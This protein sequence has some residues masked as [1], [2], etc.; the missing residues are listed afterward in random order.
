MNQANAST[1]PNKVGFVF[2]VVLGGFHFVWALLVLSGL[3]QPIY[4]FIL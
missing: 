1:N 4:D 3:A 2:A